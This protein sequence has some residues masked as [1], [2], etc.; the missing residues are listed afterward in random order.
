M[1]IYLSQKG[2][3]LAF[4][5]FHKMKVTFEKHLKIFINIAE[6]FYIITFV[7]FFI[8]S[9]KS[10]QKMGKYIITILTL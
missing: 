2:H 1:I 10:V 9:Q 8:V 6:I 5:H 4:H 3:E 7:S